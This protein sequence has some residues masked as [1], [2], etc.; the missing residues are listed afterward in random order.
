MLRQIF[1]KSLYSELCGSS[2]GFIYKKKKKKIIDLIFLG[3]FSTSFTHLNFSH[4]SSQILDQAQGGHKASVWTAIFSS[5][6][7]DLL[8]GSSQGFDYTLRVVVVLKAEP[9]P[10][11]EVVCTLEQVFHSHAAKSSK[12]FSSYPQWPFSSFWHESWH[13]TLLSILM[14][15]GIR[16]IA[17]WEFVSYL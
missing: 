7:T 11:S 17:W 1:R 12:P 13:N 3:L 14:S 6:F 15:V 16:D 10:Q 5:H 4:S 8:Q 2:F 9:S